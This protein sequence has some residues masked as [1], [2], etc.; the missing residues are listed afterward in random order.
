MILFIASTL[1]RSSDYT[2][3]YL[4]F[5]F[6][7][8]HQRHASVFSCKK[9]EKHAY[10]VFLLTF[11]FCFRFLDFFKLPVCV[12]YPLQISNIN[13]SDSVMSRKRRMIAEHNSTK[14]M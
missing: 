13:T 10:M 4:F 2:G 5:F 1:C 9:K 12:L 11:F 8:L 7:I 6:F 3:L 14:R